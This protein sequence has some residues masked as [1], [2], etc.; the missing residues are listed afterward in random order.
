MTTATLIKESFSLGLAYNF[1]GL[2]HDPHG[3]KHGGMQTVEEGA[4]SSTSGS[5]GSRKG[6]VTLGLAGASETSK[7]TPR[8]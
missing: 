2:D 1:R 5:V 6:T 4:E 7:P 8:E 3:R